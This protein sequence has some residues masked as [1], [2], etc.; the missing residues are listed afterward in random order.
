M[1]IAAIAPVFA[2]DL[3]NFL[4]VVSGAGT[5]LR[6]AFDDFAIRELRWQLNQVINRIS[7]SCGRVT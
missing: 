5:L 4:Y 7:A 2:C 6:M 1:A 3:H